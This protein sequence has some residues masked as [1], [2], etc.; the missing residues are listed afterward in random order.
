LPATFEGLT[1]PGVE[2]IAEAVHGLP[3]APFAL[4]D[5]RDSQRERIG[6]DPNVLATDRSMAAT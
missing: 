1:R 3:L 4:E 2:W 5:R 6:S